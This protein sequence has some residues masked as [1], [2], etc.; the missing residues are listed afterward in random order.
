MRA[1]WQSMP[2]DQ[3]IKNILFKNPPSVF[4]PLSNWMFRPNPLLYCWYFFIVLSSLRSKIERWS[5]RNATP[6]VVPVFHILAV[7]YI[8]IEAGALIWTPETDQGSFVIYYL[9]FMRYLLQRFFTQVHF[10]AVQCGS[11]NHS[12]CNNFPPSIVNNMF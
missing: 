8:C 7:Q 11:W 12:E 9:Y 4:V 5:S 10:S 1:L 2:D 6:E 3:K